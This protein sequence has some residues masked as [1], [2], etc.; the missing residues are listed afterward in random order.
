MLIEKHLLLIRAV[1]L[2]DILVIIGSTVHRN[3]NTVNIA[4]DIHRVVTS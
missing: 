2:S 4:I 3:D 1:G